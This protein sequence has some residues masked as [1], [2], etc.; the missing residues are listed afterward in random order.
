MHIQFAFTVCLEWK[1]S[2]LFLTD[3]FQNKKIITV[4]QK[5]GTSK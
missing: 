1:V 2:D 3:M 5:N 4:F